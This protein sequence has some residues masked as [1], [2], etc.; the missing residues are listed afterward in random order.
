MASDFHKINHCDDPG[1]SLASPRCNI[2]RIFA[3]KP[4]EVVRLEPLRFDTSDLVLI[5]EPPSP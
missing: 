3:A 1:C 5:E 4:G 2:A